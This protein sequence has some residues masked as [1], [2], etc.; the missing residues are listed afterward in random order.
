M[1]LSGELKKHV[2][3][4]F[5]LLFSAG[6]SHPLPTS[7]WHECMKVW[8]FYLLCVI[9]LLSQCFIHL[10]NNDTLEVQLH[11]PAHASE[12][13]HAHSQ[14]HTSLSFCLCEDIHGPHAGLYPNPKINPRLTPKQAK[15]W[16]PNKNS[17]RFSSRMQIVVLS[18]W[19]VQEHTHTCA[20]TQFPTQVDLTAAL[21]EPTPIS[22]SCSNTQR[23]SIPKHEAQI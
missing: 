3:C 15:L 11:D 13:K 12:H 8:I 9:K 21:F 2:V 16:E 10:I 5:I 14:A 22:A 20:Y 23:P 7:R 6:E 19:Q 18:M 1:G 17:P 4:I